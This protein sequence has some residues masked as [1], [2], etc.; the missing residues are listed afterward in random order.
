M[1]ASKMVLILTVV[2]MIAFYATS[3][4]SIAY[5]ASRYSYRKLDGDTSPNKIIELMWC[6]L[7]IVLPIALVF[8]ENLMNN[9]QSVSIIS[10]FP[11]GIIM[12][13]IIC[14]FFKDCGKYIK[15]NNQ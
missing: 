15:E 2:C 13:I 1:P 7:L 11:I 4:D 3:F 14:S 6:V 5:T 9:I 10:A 8:S 12:V